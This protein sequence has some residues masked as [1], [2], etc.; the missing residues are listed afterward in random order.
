MILEIGRAAS[1]YNIC[2]ETMN[3]FTT[4]VTSTL[5]IPE[6]LHK[7]IKVL[8]KE[9]KEVIFILH[10]NEKLDCECLHCLF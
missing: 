8:E 6:V 2:Y 9:T 4:S 7:I 5:N 1:Y 10:L 3:Y